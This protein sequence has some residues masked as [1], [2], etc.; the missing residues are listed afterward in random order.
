MR[1]KTEKPIVLHPLAAGR[2]FDKYKNFGGSLA[3]WV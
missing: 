2:H 3:M 1:A